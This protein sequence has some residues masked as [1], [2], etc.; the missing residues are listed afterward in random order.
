LAAVSLAFAMAMACG[1]DDQETSVLATGSTSNS[2]AGT[3]GGGVGGSSVGGFG[4]GNAQAFPEDPILDGSAPADSATLFGDAT[5]GNPSGGPCLVEPEMGALY[6]NNW[7]TPRFVF[8]P[9]AGQNLFEIRLQAASQDN[10]LVLY[11]SASE[12]TMPASLW[13]AVASAVA[14]EPITVRIRG[15]VFDG[16]MLSEPPSLGTTGEIGVAPVGANGT[17]VYWTTTNGSALKGFSVEDFTV[18]TVL[19]PA[20]VQQPTSGGQVT[21]IG[22]HTSTPDGE[23][24]SFTAQ[25]PWANALAAI[26][27]PVGVQPSFMTAAAVQALSQP[28][29]L[30]IH[31][32]SAAHW[33]A[34]DRIM[35]TPRGDF[36]AAELAWFDLEAS[37]AAQ[38]SA[39][40]VLA[41]TGDLRG[42]GSP[43]WSHDGQTIVYVS[44][45]AQYT[46]RLDNGVADLYTVPYNDKQGGTATP[47]AGA[48][49]A[50]RAEYYP[51]FSADDQLIA[52]N[53][54][55]MGN[56]MYDQP[57]AE[58]HVILAGGG[59]ATRLV[60]NDPAA[61]SGVV[62]PGVTNS[63]PKWAPEA[64]VDA[65]R[66]F[67]WLVFS[68]R[69]HSGNPQLY[70]TAVVVDSSGGISTH[71]AIYLHNQPSNENNHTPTWDVFKL[72][73]PN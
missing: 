20:Q 41:R 26:G 46:G 28:V 2:S 52:F 12:W 27:T 50:N 64:P 8:Q 69:R 73:P 9:V 19:E 22:C 4:T 16:M 33:A 70:I 11:T 29:P 32:Y 71:G 54:I 6:P 58:L 3:G 59:M 17:V 7:L 10:D 51:A 56:T 67:H 37:S 44:T 43:S 30:G 39:W 23:Y 72:P 48:A 62:S 49:D 34:G 40:D 35:V 66:T 14:D 57:L 21:C 60:A 45:D 55:P 18:S 53:A 5:N 68:S 24:A 63:W 15:A 31:T 47:L 61:C 13:Q 42:A 25:S 38:G 36:A 1:A 65:G